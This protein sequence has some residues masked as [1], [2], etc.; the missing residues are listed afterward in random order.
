MPLALV[1]VDEIFE[2][3]FPDPDTTSVIGT[4]AQA[5]GVVAP[6][7]TVTVMVVVETPLAV[8]LDGEAVIVEFVG[9]ETQ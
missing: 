4:L 6:S 7:L 2:M 8:R 5:A 1:A 3:V 9:S